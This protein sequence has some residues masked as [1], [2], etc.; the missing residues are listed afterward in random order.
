MSTIQTL[1]PSCSA[2]NRV[3]QARLMD[4]PK[5][6]KCQQPLFLG[7]SLALDDGGF[8]RLQQ[9][10]QLPLVVDFWAQ[11][12]GPCRS[13]APVFEAAAARLEP[14]ARFVKL[15]TERAV[16]TAQ[17]YAIRSIPTLMVFQGNQV[18]G[19]QAGA[20]PPASLGQWL[21]SLGIGQP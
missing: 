21:S 12:C 3:P 18:L 10:E 2:I 20:L 5:C 1:C 19:Q 6:G 11:W 16:A 13:F 9:Y 8:S 14:A 4:Q 15:D 17:R 7:K